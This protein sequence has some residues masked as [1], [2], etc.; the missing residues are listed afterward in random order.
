MKSFSFTLLLF[1]VVLLAQAQTNPK[2]SYRENFFG[3][4]VYLANGQKVKAAEIEKLMSIFPEDAL[5]FS[6]A[7]HKKM[8]GESFRWGGWI[9]ATGSLVYL[10]SGEINQQRALIV[11]GMTLGAFTLSTIS[12][13]IKRNG[14]RETSHA[15]ESFNYKVSRGF[16]YE[17]SL[18]IK[19]SP[20]AMGLSLNF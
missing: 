2:I 11:G 9:L 15:I 13:S 3:N 20:L 17:P 12:L 5:S 7:N 8:M 6:R 14:K 4:H 18:N 19:I 16:G 1:S 10:F